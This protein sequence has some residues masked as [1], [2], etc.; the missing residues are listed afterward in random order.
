MRVL[1]ACHDPIASG[2]EFDSTLKG[3]IRYDFVD[4]Y[5]YRTE[6]IEDYDEA[7]DEEDAITLKYLDE[8]GRPKVGANLDAMNTEIDALYKSK[9]DP[10]RYDALMADYSRAHPDRTNYK[11]WDAIPSNTYDYVF[12]VYCS[13]IPWE[14]RGEVNA[15]TEASLGTFTEFVREAVRVLKNGGTFLMSN[16]FF[17]QLSPESRRAINDKLTPLGVDVS[18]DHIGKKVDQPMTALN[19]PFFWE[20]SQEGSFWE[21][22]EESLVLRCVKRVVGG[23]NR[24]TRR[25]RRTVM[26]RRYKRVSPMLGV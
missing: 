25:R 18:F 2:G 16:W 19:Y 23:R 12:S 24:K 13:V 5:D 9:Y 21:T 17:L 10:S 26:T 1:L 22:K 3:D 7:Y 6:F 14:T 4:I 8:D 20:R 15:L 11:T